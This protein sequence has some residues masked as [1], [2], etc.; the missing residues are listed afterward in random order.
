MKE[1]R[2]EFERKAGV[3]GSLFASNKWSLINLEDL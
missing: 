1:Q 2:Q 3:E